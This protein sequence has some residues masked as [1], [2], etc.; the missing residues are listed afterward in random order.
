MKYNAGDL[1]K[2]LEQKHRDDIFVPE[3]KDGQTWNRHHLRLDGWA[4][5]RSYSNATMTGYE[6]KVSRSDFLNDE[7]WKLYLPYC[8]KFYFVSAPG[9]IDPKE[10][11]PEAGLLVCSANA[12]KLFEKKRSI[13]RDVEL[14][15]DLLLYILVSRTKIVDSYSQNGIPNAEY[16]KKWLTEKNESRDLGRSVSQKLRR[17]IDEKVGDIKRENDALRS[18]NKNLQLIKIA[19]ERLRIDIANASY[20]NVDD[21]IKRAIDIL[22]TNLE[23]EVETLHRLLGDMKN[24]IS[25]LKQGQNA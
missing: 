2:L 12:K 10:L 16:W 9:I 6:V 13:H 19:A 7:K 4:M 24:K 1:V 20:W 8:N 21:K 15:T 11:P 18:E 14:P 17:I 5:K 25:E 22:P 3:C 23:S